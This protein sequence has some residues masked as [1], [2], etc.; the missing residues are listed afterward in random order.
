MHWPVKCC[1][2]TRAAIDCPR[3]ELGK[4]RDRRQRRTGTG[5]SGTLDRTREQLLPFEQRQID[6]HGDDTLTAGDQVLER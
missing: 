6:P 1:I 3:I 4:P 5:Q 2:C